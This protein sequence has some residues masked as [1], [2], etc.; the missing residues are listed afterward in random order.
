MNPCKSGVAAFLSEQQASFRNKR[1]AKS[2]VCGVV[3]SGV[4]I[5]ADAYLKLGFSPVELR[6]P[7]A[8]CLVSGFLSTSVGSE[9]RNAE[10]VRAFKSMCSD[11]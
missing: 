3:G 6:I 4:L 5:G 7:F 10:S 8:L 2:L 1:M 11:A 9:T